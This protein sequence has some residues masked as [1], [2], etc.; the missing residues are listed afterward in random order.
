MSD[1]W[2]LLVK[3]HEIVYLANLGLAGTLVRGE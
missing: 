1:V 3:L 2:I